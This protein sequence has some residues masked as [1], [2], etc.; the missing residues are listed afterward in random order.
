[1]GF[2]CFRSC[3]VRSIFCIG[4]DVAGLT[5]Y[6]ADM[7]INPGCGMAAGGACFCSVASAGG[8]IDCSCN[9]FWPEVAATPGNLVMACGMAV[10]TKQVATACCHMDI[11]G[12][13]CGCAMGKGQITTFEVVAA[14][15]LGVALEA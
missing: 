5:G 11:K 10:L 14:A 2:S 6:A 15:T 7:L 3:S 8:T 1:M 9:F 13:I 12:R 4:S